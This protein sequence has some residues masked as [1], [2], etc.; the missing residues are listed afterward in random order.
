[1][2]PIV[3]PKW[4]EATFVRRYKRF[5]ADVMLPDGQLLT[6]HC[7]NTGSMLHCLVEGSPCYYSLSDNPRR[8]LKGT[9]ELVTSDCGGLVCVNTQ[10]ANA[11]VKELLLQHRLDELFDYENLKAEQ[12]PPGTSSRIDFLLCGTGQ[13]W[14]EV[15]SVTLARQPHLAE[16]PDTVTTRGQK[17][18]K[19]LQ[20]LVEAGSRACLLFVVL[21][22]RAERFRIAADL[23]PLYAEIATQVAADGVN[24][25]AI[26]IEPRPDGFFYAGRLPLDI[27]PG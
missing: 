3:R 21:V 11:L 13:T 27:G 15:K 2:Q 26:H 17:H 8:K 7:P 25:A 24:M 18:L 1:M 19:E 22:Q 12:K 23:D 5:F 10:R 16:F 4:L 9:L 6:L 14:L 20:Q